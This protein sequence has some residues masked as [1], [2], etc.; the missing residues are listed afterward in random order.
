[1]LDPCA[2]TASLR[3]TLGEQ[4][5]CKW[6]DG[7]QQYLRGPHDAEHPYAVP[8]RAH[9]LTGLAPALVL[10]GA[11]DPMRDEALDYAAR[12]RAAG[13]AVHSPVL[14]PATGWPDSLERAP[15]DACPCRDQ[16]REHV[17]AFFSGT[18]PVPS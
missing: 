9:R 5:G 12:L 14:G 6:A 4:T 11:D 2:A 7:W 17:T 3:V 8:G 10:T 18:V 16:V 15:S 1:M 13:V